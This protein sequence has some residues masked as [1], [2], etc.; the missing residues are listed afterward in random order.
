M[1]QPITC[2]GTQAPGKQGW[3]G[4]WRAP[5]N[6]AQST[7]VHTFSTLRKLVTSLHPAPLVSKPP[8]SEAEHFSPTGGQVSCPSPA[9]S[10]HS[11]ALP[12]ERA[13]LASSPAP[14]REATKP[15]HHTTQ[16][17]PSP[18]SGIRTGQMD[19]RK[20]DPDR[21]IPSLPAYARGEAAPPPGSA[22]R[23]KQMGNDPHP[24]THGQGSQL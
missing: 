12:G 17:H 4:W 11:Q 13:A 1:V 15:G 7:A 20:S 21:H 10:P 23:R 9:L 5:V 8:S 16:P 24:L 2:R 3:P 19:T 6:P 14:N 22:P 18:G